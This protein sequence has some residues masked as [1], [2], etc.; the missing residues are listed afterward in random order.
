MQ[1]YAPDEDDGILVAPYRRRRSP[2]EVS[3][4]AFARRQLADSAH[5]TVCRDLLPVVLVAWF[6][7]VA[8]SARSQPADSPSARSEPHEALAFYEGTWTPQGK[9]LGRYRESCAW[10][11]GGRR[12]VV[13]TARADT[14]NGPVESLGV[15]SYDPTRG[16]YLYH[17]FGSRGAVSTE[18]GQRISNGFRFVSESGVGADRV[19]TRFTITEGA[20]GR[21]N[22]V[23]EVAKADGPWVVEEE[24]EYLRT[25]P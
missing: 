10:L 7:S 18:R 15:Y 14:A 13:C 20:P 3:M 4:K 9:K 16:E 2:R 23:N 22:T 1:Q 19:R 25:R 6:A 24:L 8:V 5:G 17:G 21:V 12:H 11:T